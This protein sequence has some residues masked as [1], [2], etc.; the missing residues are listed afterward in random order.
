VVAR[1]RRLASQ[2]RVGHAGTLDPLAEGVLPILLGR[3][4]RLADFIQSGRKTYIAKVQLGTATETDDRE[5]A[6]IATH[7]VPG[8]SHS[9]IEE[10]LLPF[11]GEIL[12]T[13]PKYSAL[14]VSGQRAYALARA[15]APVELAPR[16]ITVDSLRLLEHTDTVLTLE[17][18]CS[19]GTYIRALARDIAQALGTVGHMASLVRT[20]VGS[21][22][23]ED[24]VSLD[25]L[26]SRPL[27]ASLLPADRAIPEAQVFHANTV[28][29]HRFANGQPLQA[30]GLQADCIWVYDPDG[31][32]IG[33]GS[34]DRDWLRPRLAL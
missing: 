19:K 12:Q 13:P 5:G 11:T 1:V 26:A 27:E 29:G 32:L 25:D 6:V 28:E 9:A 30:A 17:I 33:L 4:T 34:A 7:A 31:R 18:V 20:R 22:L 14:K 2:K 3:A 8:L 21:F 24:A 16:L 10:A 15:G 23:L